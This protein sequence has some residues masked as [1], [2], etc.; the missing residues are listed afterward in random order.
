MPYRILCF[1][2]GGVRGVLT[3]MLVERL[4][5]AW[6][7]LLTEVDL[8]SGTSSGGILALGLA[9]GRTPDEC[10]QLYQTRGAQV[11]D[12]SI[13]DNVRDLGILRGAQYSNTHLRRALIDLF[14][15]MTLGD[16]P[17]KVLIA[18]FALDNQGQELDGHRHWKPKFFHNY[19]GPGSD[20]DQKVADVAL[21]T[22]AAPTYFP[23]YQGYVDGGV[24]AP[25]PSLCA[26]AQAINPVFGA[27]HLDQVA[28][29]SIGTGRTSNY[30]TEQDA[31][32]GLLQWA[33]HLL[34][35]VT[36]AS[37]SLPD[38]QCRQI[39]G[40]RYYRLN[41]NLPKPV[42]LDD[43]QQASHLAAL[44]EQTDLSPIKQWLSA[45]F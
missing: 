36:E 17:K 41:P 42:R 5:Q 37:L 34:G 14:G 11:F 27:Q 45:Y 22:S 38:Y 15:D 35:L 10:N 8:L 12:D 44:A 33:P 43:I 6:P 30:L 19:P 40:E 21:R 29:L 39:L 18:S 9:A 1:D 4:V 20:A 3:A 28:L 13:F 26:L 31:D 16:L 32:W 25:N 23:I 24:V 7:A 2:G